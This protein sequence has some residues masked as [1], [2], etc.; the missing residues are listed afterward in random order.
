MTFAYAWI[1]IVLWAALA[2][3]ARNA[4]QRSLVAKAGT[5]GATLARFLYGLPFAAA[6]V[7]LLH[8][9]PMTSGAVPPFN[10]PY[11]SWLMLGALGQ[12]G[13]TACLLAAMKQRN[14]VVGVAFSKTDA[15]QVALFA[16]LFLHEVPG[17][18]TMLA[19]GLATAGVVLLSMPQKAAALAGGARAWSSAAALYGL[20]SGAG[21][22]LSAVGY[23]G[24]A[25]QLPGVSPWLIGA[26]GVLLAQA[27]QSLLLGGW[28]AWTSR[29]SLGAIAREWRVSTAAGCAGALAS[30]GWF[31]AFA[32]TS[33][34]N[35]RTL[36]LVE[37]I[38]SYVVSHRLM[39]ER[40]TTAE[41]AGL[42]LVA[43]GL[44]ALCMQL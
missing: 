4:A 28:L 17:W 35:V 42:A 34:A 38:F 29:S 23:R 24:A 16:A 12:L 37:V 43:I 22:A 20:A 31:T 41:Q 7:A 30:I 19:I 40:L 3:T 21:F 36:G 32:L 39:R 13:A 5:L 2:Q 26:W 15:L 8:A 1:P 10:L 27:A 33:A 18:L 11:V 9:L 44:L 6:W 14:F 25:L